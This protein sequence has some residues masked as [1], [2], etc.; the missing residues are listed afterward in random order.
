M[1]YARL[2]LA[3]SKKIIKNAVDR[4]RLKRLVRESFR[5]NQE[6]LGAYDV[7]VLARKEVSK[8]PRGDLFEKQTKLWTALVRR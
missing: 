6:N 7:I 1:P 4:N 2:G 5:L 3:I 8:V